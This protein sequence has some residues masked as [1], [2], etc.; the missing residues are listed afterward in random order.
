MDLHHQNVCL[1]TPDSRTGEIPIPDEILNRSEFFP[2]FQNA[3]GACDGTHILAKVP[4]IDQQR[5]RCRKGFTSQNVFAA[6]SFDFRFLFIH[7]GWEG[8]AHDGRVLEDAEGNGFSIPNGKYYLFDAG[9]RLKRGCLT[10]YRG[11][12]YHLKEQGTQRPENKEELFNLRHAK[13]RNVIERIFGALKK[14]YGILRTPCEYPLPTQVDLVLGLTALY[15][16][17]LAINGPGVDSEVV[18][19]EC[20]EDEEEENENRSAGN[21]RDEEEGEDEEEMKNFRDHLAQT[22]WEDYL[23][24]RARRGY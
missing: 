15:N 14:R 8:S 11:I 7:P 13:L 24:Y 6:C 9:Y 5:F 21:D 10:P 3:I 19:N 16:L 12:R 20:N 22:M 4:Y 2:Y 17:I 1:P 23:Q 18:G